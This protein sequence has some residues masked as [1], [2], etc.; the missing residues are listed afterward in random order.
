MKTT[1]LILI[2][3]GCVVSLLIIWWLFA[4]MKSFIKLKRKTRV[5]YKGLCRSVSDLHKFTDQTMA[6]L[7]EFG[8]DAER[9]IKANNDAVS[10]KRPEAK[11]EC[12]AIL[13]SRLRKYLSDISDKTD[14][15]EI[16][17]E[18]AEIET[19]IFKERKNYNSLVREFNCKRKMFPDR[20]VG[21]IFRFKV[22]E[23]YTADEAEAL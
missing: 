8:N 4:T 9:V 11:A 23:F 22:F 3:V 12:D 7:K 16:E 21:A 20:I 2:I 18:L 6:D 5:A 14:T 13:R 15:S 19:E 1:Q 10:A 17:K